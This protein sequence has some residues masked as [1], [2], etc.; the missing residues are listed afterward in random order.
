MTFWMHVSA[1][2]FGYFLVIKELYETVGSASLV[3]SK[4]G[5][6]NGG[7]SIKKWV[8]TIAYLLSVTEYEQIP[9]LKW[10]KELLH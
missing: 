3:S 5:R 8:Y 2:S 7:R 9:I 6:T 1:W 10:V 4:F